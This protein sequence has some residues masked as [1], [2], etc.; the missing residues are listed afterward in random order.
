MGIIEADE[1]NLALI[2]K[3]EDMIE[4]RFVDV[5]DHAGRRL[6]VTP[7]RVNPFALLSDFSHLSNE[8]FG[9][10]LRYAIKRWVT[11]NYSHY[12]QPMLPEIR[13]LVLERDGA[14]CCYCGSLDDLTIDHI[15]PVVRGGGEE[16]DNYC[17]ACR[18]CNASKHALTPDE[19]FAKLGI[20]DVS[21]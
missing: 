21:H 2:L 17:V 4:V 10:L 7:L 14:E 20:S 18:A 15:V 16:L 3:G 11:L 5:F 1:R 6:H 9:R 13:E 8:R 12:R 19:W